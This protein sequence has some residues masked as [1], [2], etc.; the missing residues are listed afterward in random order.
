MTVLIIITQIYRVIGR[1]GHRVIEK[2]EPWL[3]VIG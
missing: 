2:Q 3:I 1:S